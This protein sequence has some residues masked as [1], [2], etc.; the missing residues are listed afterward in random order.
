MQSNKPSKL[1]Y[2]RAD[3][4]ALGGFLTEPFE[5]T[6][7]VLAPVSL[8]AVG[9]FATARSEAFNAHEI[10][11]CSAAYTRVSGQQHASDGSIS[12]L[13]TAVVENL[14]I[15]EVVRADRIVAQVSIEIPGD[16][17]SRT[18]SFAG[19]CFDGLRVAG[20]ATQ[21]SVN[22]DAL[23]AAGGKGGGNVR[24]I[25]TGFDQAVA[26]GSGGHIVDIPGFG[27]F[28]FGEIVVTQDAIQLMAL[29]AELGC[30]VGGKVGVACAGGGGQGVH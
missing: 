19:S 13:V 29:R 1:Y 3:A 7:P 20:R 9:G 26:G 24:T 23:R 21:P 2:L 30:P 12:I 16:A 5:S 14:N 25:V 22:P 6:I 27:R 15:L 18:I 17:G 11:S 28:Y 10:I 4:N 8:P